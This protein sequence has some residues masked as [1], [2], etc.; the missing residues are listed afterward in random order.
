M[1][2]G[3]VATD[4]GGAGAPLTVEQSVRAMRKAIAGLG[5]KQQGLFLDQEGRP[6][7][8]W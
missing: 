6:F 3:W 1:S 5:K 8:G 7:E 4:M 2:P